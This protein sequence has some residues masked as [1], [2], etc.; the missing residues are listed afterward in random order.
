MEISEVAVIGKA[1]ILQ[2]MEDGIRKK[3]PS[4]IF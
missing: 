3:R 2:I 1:G 4:Q